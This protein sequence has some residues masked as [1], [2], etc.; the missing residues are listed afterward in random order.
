MFLKSIP[1]IIDY[2]KRYCILL[3][4]HHKC[5]VLIDMTDLKLGRR[6][7]QI[8]AQLYNSGYAPCLKKSSREAEEFIK[9]CQAKQQQLIESSPLYETSK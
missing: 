2:C 3:K 7:A 5:D 9:T 4:N 1:Y 6:M 8:T